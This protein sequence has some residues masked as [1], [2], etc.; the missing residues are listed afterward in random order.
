MN[1]KTYVRVSGAIFSVVALMHALRLVLKWDAVIGGWVVPP[2]FSAVALLVAGTLAT[3]AF[4]L[5]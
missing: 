1:P 5:K 2:W 3:T 4:R